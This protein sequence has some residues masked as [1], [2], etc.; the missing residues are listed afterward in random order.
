VILGGGA[1]TVRVAVDVR[2]EDEGVS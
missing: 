2:P 1:H